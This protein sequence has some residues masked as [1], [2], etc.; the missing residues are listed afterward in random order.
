MPVITIPVKQVKAQAWEGYKIRT[1][2]ELGGNK[3]AL[4]MPPTVAF[5]EPPAADAFKAMQEASD[6]LMQFTDMYRS[7]MFQIKAR[8]KAKGSAKYRLLAPATKSGHN[9]A[10]SFDLSVRET[11]R[12]FRASKNPELVAAGA[13]RAA[14]GEWMKQFGWTG[15]RSESWHF[16]FLEGHSSTVSKINAKYG[17]ALKLNNHDVQRCLNDLLKDELEKPLVVDGILGRKTDAAAVMAYPRL[18]LNRNEAIGATAWFRRVLA[19]ATAKV[20]DV[21]A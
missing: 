8:I 5:F 15:I 18:D 10:W 9:F 6:Y 17:D 16:N 4:K 21:D 12:D 1:K 13:N 14:L 3:K 11:L 20:V 2:L 7:V 19:G